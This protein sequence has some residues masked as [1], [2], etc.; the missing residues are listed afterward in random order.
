[1][2][3]QFMTRRLLISRNK[4]ETAVHGCYCPGDM[5]VRM[6][7]V[8]AIPGGVGTCA[9][10]LE[11]VLLVTLPL[12]LPLPYQF[13]VCLVSFLSFSLSRSLGAHRRPEF[14]EQPLCNCCIRRELF[15]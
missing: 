7:K 12:P 2:A 13:G 10:V 6:R 8:L 9:S 4:G 15:G 11:L 14:S 3:R 1:M 5:A